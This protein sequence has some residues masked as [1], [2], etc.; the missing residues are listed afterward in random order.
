MLGNPNRYTA[1]WRPIIAVG[2]IAGVQAAF[3]VADASLELKL[4]VQRTLED[5][6][7]LKTL[8]YQLEAQQGA[9]TQAQVAPAPELGL[10]VE[11]MLGTGAFKDIGAAETTLNLGWILERGKRQYYIDAARAGTSMLEARAGIARLDAVARTARL[12]LDNLEAQERVKLA[13]EA[14]KTAEDAVKAIAERVRAGR[15]PPG[16]LARAEAELARTRLAA[17]DLE[18]ELATARNQLSAQWGVLHPDFQLVVG[19][20]EKLP[21][22]ASFETLMA[23]LDRS[24]QMAAYLTEQRL[25]EANLRVAQS[26]AKPDWRLDASVRRF[27]FTDDHAFVASITIPLT[28]ADRNRGRVQQA[29]ARLAQVD[30]ERAASRLEIE[31]RLFSIYEALQHSL[32]RAETLREEV[33]P[34]MQR[35]VTEIRRGYAAGRYSYYELQQLQNELLAYRVS[36]LEASINARRNIVEIEQLTGAMLPAAQSTP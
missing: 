3:A 36:L 1:W 20:W 31:T 28:S 15:T 19:N 11:N 4:A 32:H 17:E 16:D 9:V 5:N 26:Q 6:P 21:R 7:A 23:Q 18:H 8:G 34:A 13:L 29:G 25:Q 2:L 12:F 30:A 35:A 14:T 22:P 33:L 27:E 10:M 24:P